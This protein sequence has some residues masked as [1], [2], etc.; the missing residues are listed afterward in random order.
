M[1]SNLRNYLKSYYSKIALIVIV[2]IVTFNFV[3]YHFELRIISMI[4]V[5][6][7]FVGLILFLTYMVYLNDINYRESLASHR[8]TEEINVGVVITDRNTMITYVNPAFLAITGYKQDEVIGK[9]ISILKSNKH[10]QDFYHVMWGKLNDKGEWQGEIWD[11]KKNGEIYPKWL[12]IKT[13]E[14]NNRLYGYLGLFY[15]LSEFKKSEKNIQNF[16]VLTGLPNKLIFENRLEEVIELAKAKKQAFCLM[17][18]NINNFKRLNDA[19]GFLFGDKIILETSRRVK[20]KLTE[21]DILSRIDGNQFMLVFPDLND[22]EEIVFKAQDMLEI[23]NT[24]INVDDKEVFIQ[25]SIGLVVYPI[26]GINKG[27]LIK[28]ASLTLHQANKEG[29]NEFKLYSDFYNIIEN[30]KIEIENLLRKAVIN[31]EFSLRYQPQLNLE[32]GKI[33]GCEALLR[34]EQPQLGMVFPEK[35]IPVAEE[36]GLMKKIG[37]WVLKKACIQCKA[38]NEMGYD[39]TMAVNISP[40]QF[41]DDNLIDYI[42]QALNDS[43]LDPSKLEVEITEGMLMEDINNVIYKLKRIKEFGLNIAVD[44]FG[45][46]YSSLHYIKKFPIDKIKIDKAFITDYPDKDDGVIAKII[47]ELTHNLNKNVI[48][49]GVENQRQ[50]D[51]MK[52]IE[53]DEI[54]GFFISKPLVAEEFEKLLEEYKSKI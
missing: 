44:D 6:I 9:S 36:K 11:K 53:C 50:L 10:D 16:D 21:N 52:K 46:G 43:K 17:A 28:N 24:P 35:F 20:E 1:K 34:W 19:Y 5:S 14:K 31:D 45:T 4:L 49:E 22:F 13:I 25:I 29:I 54:Q 18:L 27:M 3:F 2:I 33:V 51:Y 47:V 41:N 15:D 23:T 12:R 8:L 42:D 39:L 7:L 40:V 32:T 37:N 30:Q 48:A 38:W 26:D